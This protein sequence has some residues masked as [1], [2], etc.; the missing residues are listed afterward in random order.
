[1]KQYTE[2]SASVL[3]WEKQK[4]RK[5]RNR[6]HNQD[7]W[8]WKMYVSILHWD[9]IFFLFQ[10]N[11]IFPTCF[12]FLSAA[13]FPWDRFSEY[14]SKILGLEVYWS[15]NDFFISWKGSKL[16]MNAPMLIEYL[17]IFMLI[18]IS[19]TIMTCYKPPL[20]NFLY[21]NSSFPPFTHWKIMCCTCFV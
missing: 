4:F 9:K 17:K 1:M 7:L 12:L 10:R 6:S 19:Y 8:I 3:R 13:H 2:T 14:F 11:I 15:W 5:T 20:S 16:N 21:F 18:D